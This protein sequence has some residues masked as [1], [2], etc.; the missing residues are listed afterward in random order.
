MSDR[1]EQQ[2]L[3]GFTDP[4]SD[5]SLIFRSVL[6][7]MAKPGKICMPN[8]N[9]E[10][11]GR[12]DAMACAIALTLCDM[13]TPI[14]LSEDV[15]SDAVLN[16][17]IFHTGVRLAR[18]PSEA[19]FVF[20]G[21]GQRKRMDMLRRLCLGEDAYPDRS[22]TLIMMVHTIDNSADILLK[23]PGISNGRTISVAPID[24]SFWQWR[25][26]IE[27]LFPLGVDVLFTSNESI[28]A[29]PRSTRVTRCQ[30]DG[31]A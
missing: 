18:D 17:L 22:A 9:I 6:D 30:Q 16:H 27:M 23:G 14:W 21:P 24:G 8:C 25:Q 20:V 13:E 12:F 28:M 7:A 29:L 10:P 1:K 26:E 15:W 19:K 2:I 3:P 11:P 5:S 31:G 4:G